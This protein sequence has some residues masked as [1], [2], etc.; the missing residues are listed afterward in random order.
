MSKPESK[1]GLSPEGEAR[2]EAM[3][4]QLQDELVSVHHKRRQRTRVAK[5][6]SFVAVVAIAGLAWSFLVLMDDAGN[7]IVEG[8]EI[9]SPA[10]RTSIV[11]VSN[12]AGI[13]DRCVVEN[14]DS[15]AAIETM[16]DDELL[17]MLAAVGRP[18]VLGEINGE[19]RVISDAPPAR[20]QAK[21]L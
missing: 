1:N 17:A 19:V 8:T 11:A 15:S 21:T 9:V 18:S 16:E 2:K 14:S 6:A 10:L 5:G 3:L 20:R 12:V 4:S 7:Q 13:D